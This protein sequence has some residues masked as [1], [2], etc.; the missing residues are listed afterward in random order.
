[1]YIFAGQRSREK[2]RVL[3]WLLQMHWKRTPFQKCASSNR[4]NALWCI[5]IVSTPL[6]V[7]QP[8]CATP[9]TSRPFHLLPSSPH[10]AGYSWS[11]PPRTRA[12]RRTKCGPS[13]VP[14]PVYCCELVAGL[15]LPCPRRRRR[16]CRPRHP[17]SLCQQ[18]VCMYF[19]C[20][21]R[22]SRVL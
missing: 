1:M 4:I 10:A 15:L 18:H 14:V 21:C 19:G 20:C 9:K 6:S 17:L 3:Q 22:A 5:L 16:A 13:R 7:P 2:S 11:V 12:G 8:A